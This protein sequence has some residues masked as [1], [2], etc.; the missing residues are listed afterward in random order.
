MVEPDTES[1]RFEQGTAVLLT[2]QHGAVFKGIVS[3]NEILTEQA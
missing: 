3:S 2:E 1:A